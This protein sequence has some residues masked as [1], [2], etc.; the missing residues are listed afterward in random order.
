VREAQ[1]ALINDLMKSN[2]TTGPAIVVGLTVLRPIVVPAAARI[3]KPVP[4]SAIKAGIIVLEKG[5][6]TLA[7]LGEI[8]EEICAEAGPSST[9]RP[10]R[11]QGAGASPGDD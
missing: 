3:A 6:E 7:R 5:R 10:N 8:T 11:P 1:T 2:I 4:E 9:R